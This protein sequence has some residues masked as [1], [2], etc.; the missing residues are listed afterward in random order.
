MP[1]TPA[2]SIYGREDLTTPI[3]IERANKSQEDVEE[4]FAT[5]PLLPPLMTDSAATSKQAPFQSP[6]QSP[7]VAEPSDP[8][9]LSG[10][11]TPIDAVIAH[12]PNPSIPSSPLLSTKPSISSLFHH[13][14]T[15]LTPCSEIPVLPLTDLPE[16]VWSVKLGH[17]NF[18]IQ[19]EPYV[20]STF[21]LASCRQL[22]ADWDLART[23]YTKHLVRT[24]EHYGA[25]SSTYKLTEE[26]WAL[27]E[28]AWRKNHDTTVAATAETGSDAFKGLEYNV[29]G[30]ENRDLVTKIPSLNDGRGVGKFPSLGDTEIVGPMVKVAA[31]SPALAT[32][33]LKRSAS[34]KAKLFK[35]IADKFPA[36]LVG[37]AGKS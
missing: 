26:K 9:S 23:N 37:S 12:S 30:N 33:G 31:S 18:T 19:P 5:T 28:A 4:A 17:A 14:R 35:F 10:I 3:D 27:T 20:P 16:D 36:G 24:G 25:T 34:T 32:G 7:S 22:R 21:T 8:L 13:S 11:A 29:F 15:Y 6:L 2:R 1:P